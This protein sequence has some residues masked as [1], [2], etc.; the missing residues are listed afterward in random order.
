L[1][2]AARYQFHAAAAVIAWPIQKLDGACGEVPHQ[3]DRDWSATTRDVEQAIHLQQVRTAQRRKGHG[4]AA[5]A[6]PRDRRLLRHREAISVHRQYILNVELGGER[7]LA[8][9]CA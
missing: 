7:S 9:K 5:E 6:I 4:E 8:R 3:L 2:N 1:V